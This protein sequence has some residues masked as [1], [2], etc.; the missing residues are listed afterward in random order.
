MLLQVF[1]KREEGS[2]KEIAQHLKNSQQGASCLTTRKVGKD[3]D[4]SVGRRALLPRFGYRS[5]FLGFLSDS[6]LQAG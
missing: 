6:A 3:P 2:Q 1:W 4:A 5:H